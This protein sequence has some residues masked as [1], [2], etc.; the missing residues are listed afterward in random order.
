VAGTDPAGD[1]LPAGLVLGKVEEIFDMYG[2]TP[3][4][5]SDDIINA[6]S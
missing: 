1:A 4:K 3:E 5:I 6:I 2:M